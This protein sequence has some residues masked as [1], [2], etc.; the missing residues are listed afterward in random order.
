M[1]LPAYSLVPSKTMTICADDIQSMREKCAQD[2]EGIHFFL[3]LTTIGQFNEL[4]QSFT[5]QA[6]GMQQ[7]VDDLLKQCFMVLEELD[8]QRVENGNYNVV[9]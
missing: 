3:F 7:S 4:M 8:R 9:K 5:S 2:I 6:A 1:K